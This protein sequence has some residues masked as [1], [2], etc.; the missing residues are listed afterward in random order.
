MKINTNIDLAFITLA[1]QEL[2]SGVAFHISSNDAGV[3]ILDYEHD[4]TIL[5]EAELL[6][7]A[8]ELSDKADSES[9]KNNVLLRIQQFNSN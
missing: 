5:S 8:Q 1:L 3:E 4:N 7:K 2:R 9:Y 6:A